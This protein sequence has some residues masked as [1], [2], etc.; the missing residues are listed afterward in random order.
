MENF[1]QILKREL[2]I[3][4]KHFNN[5][6]DE[7]KQEFSSFKTEIKDEMSNFKTEISGEMS[8]FKEEIRKE[9]TNFKTEVKDEIRERFFCFEQEYGRKIDGIYDVVVLNKQITDEKINDLEKRV[10]TNE[11]RI[12]KNSLEIDSL[13]SKKINSKKLNLKN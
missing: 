7:I 6:K 2:G 8:G 4:E 1:E 13:K 12:I 10:K 3:F 9:M 11:M 5:F